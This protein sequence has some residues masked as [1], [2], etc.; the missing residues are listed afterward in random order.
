MGVAET[1]RHMGID[2]DVEAL[3]LLVK[4]RSLRSLA[5]P[6]NHWKSAISGVLSTDRSGVKMF[7]IQRVHHRTLPGVHGLKRPNAAAL[8]LD[9]YLP[10]RLLAVFRLLKLLQ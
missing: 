7:C 6:V 8:Q 4:H 9:R 3:V 2:G 5:K 1:L 10:R